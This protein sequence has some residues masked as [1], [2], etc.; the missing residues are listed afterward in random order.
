ME[1]EVV[2]KQYRLDKVLGSGSFGTVFKAKDLLVNKDIAIKLGGSSDVTRNE[3]TIMK[4]LSKSPGFPIFYRSCKTP[5]GRFIAMQLLG[6]SVDDE[7]KARGGQLSNPPGVIA[8]ILRRLRILHRLGFVHRDLKLQ[9]FIYDLA[10]KKIYLTDFGMAAK[11]ALNSESSKP[12]SGSTIG[13]LK[14]CSLRAHFYSNIGPMDDVESLVYIAIFLVTGSLPWCNRACL[15]GDIHAN[16]RALKGQAPGGILRTSLPEE[17][18]EMLHYARSR[19]VSVKPDYK[20]LLRLVK[21]WGLKSTNSPHTPTLSP[22]SFALPISGK[23]SYEERNQKVKA[24]T[25]LTTEID[26]KASQSSMTDELEKTLQLACHQ[27]QMRLT[28]I[29]ERLTSSS[30]K[31]IDAYKEVALSLEELLL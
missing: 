11:C 25:V 18:I 10:R 8:S 23:S 12:A 19:C 28:G 9:N 5:Q 31:R 1:G 3:A 15:T 22:S 24:H 17:I 16:I 29:R 4:T 6:R 2:Y 13:N 26:L 7:L 20:Y 30:F 21:R 14:F 27:P